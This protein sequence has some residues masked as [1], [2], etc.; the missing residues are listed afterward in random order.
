MGEDVLISVPLREYTAGLPTRTHLVT[1]VNGQ[2]VAH[3]DRTRWTAICSMSGSGQLHRGD[4]DGV[5]CHRC[6]DLAQKRRDRDPRL[7]RERNQRLEALVSEI[8]EMADSTGLY[9][10]IVTSIAAAIQR[11]REGGDVKH[12]WV[13][14]EEAPDFQG[15]PCKR[16]RC[17]RCGVAV[18]WFATVDPLT[19]RG[20]RCF[21][22]RAR[23]QREEQ[24]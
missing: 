1:K 12:E 11:Y 5:T 22:P 6:R 10:E 16:Y 21:A 14:V 23:R 9:S 3:P 13:Y 7:L 24:G 8:E 19:A 17:K 20:G 15:M 2:S 4:L 18:E